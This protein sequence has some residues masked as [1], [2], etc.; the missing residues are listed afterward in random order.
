M[1]ALPLAE[2]YRIS[3]AEDRIA[4]PTVGRVRVWV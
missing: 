4:R 1:P 3:H 2:P